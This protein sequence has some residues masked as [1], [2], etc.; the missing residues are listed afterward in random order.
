MRKLVV[1]MLCLFVV[2]QPLQWP[3]ILLS[4]NLQLKKQ[5]HRGNNNF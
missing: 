3:R 1:A 2:V 4:P 5:K